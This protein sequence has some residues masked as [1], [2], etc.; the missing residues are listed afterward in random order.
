M[1]TAR[2]TDGRVKAQTL[3]HDLQTISKSISISI[4]WKTISRRRTDGGGGGNVF[5]LIII[6]LIGL[7]WKQHIYLRAPVC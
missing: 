5:K 6:F 3:F 7:S 1:R 4:R 2:V